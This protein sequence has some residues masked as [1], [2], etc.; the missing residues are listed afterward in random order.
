MRIAASC[1]SILLLL[2]CPGATAR[3][4]RKAFRTARPVIE[5]GH[6]GGNLRPYRIAIYKD[7]RV[8]ALKGV[9]A[10][11]T[12][13]IPIEKLD[14]L[15]AKATDPN[16]WKRGRIESRPTIPDFG[17][18]FVRVRAPSGRTIYRHGAQKGPL[19]EFY[20]LLSGIVLEQ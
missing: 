12:S 17:F 11:K 3:E 6:E 4:Q 16:F 15:V 14:E 19:G 18:V 13:S 10:L 5:F 7:G 2:A 9:P 20:S 1:L 8:V